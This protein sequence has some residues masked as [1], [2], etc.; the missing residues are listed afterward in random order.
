MTTPKTHATGAS[1]IPAAE[2]CLPK[3]PQ[4]DVASGLRISIDEAEEWAAL[5]AGVGDFGEVPVIGPRALFLQ[6]DAAVRRTF[7][8]NDAPDDV[9]GALNKLAHHVE[10]F[11]VALETVARI[12][13]G[14]V[15]VVDPG[16]DDAP[17]PLSEAQPR[18]VPDVSAEMLAIVAADLVALGCPED[19]ARAFIGQALPALIQSVIEGRAKAVQG[20]Q[21]L[22]RAAAL[23]NDERGGHRPTTKLPARNDESDAEYSARMRQLATDRPG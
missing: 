14:A 21:L 17:A 10:Q 19:K 6:V 23:W 7:P 8:L 2:A 16:E 3:H 18:A 22:D 15:V 9:V 11:N 1:F 5:I 20:Q 4:P 13:L 12:V